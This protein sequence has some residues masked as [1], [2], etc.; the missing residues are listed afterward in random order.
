M[1]LLSEL[2]Q[3]KFQLKS[4]ELPSVAGIQDN[5]DKFL[6]SLTSKLEDNDVL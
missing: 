1:R 6:A 2:P 4:T 5:W 3:A